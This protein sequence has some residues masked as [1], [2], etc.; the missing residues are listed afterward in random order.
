MDTEKILKSFGFD[1]PC[2][3]CTPL[4][5][6][7]LHATYRVETADGCF[8]LQKLRHEDPAALMENIALVTAH[9]REHPG[10][11][12]PQYFRTAEGWLHDGCY[13]LMDCLPGNPLTADS[14][15][16]QTEAASFAVG[17][18]DAALHGLK[19]LREVWPAFHDTRAYLETLRHLR[20]PEG[21]TALQ[22]KAV[23]IGEA[24]CGL[25]DRM[26]DGLLPV[27]I[28][29][30]DTRAANILVSGK[31]AAVIDLDTVGSGLAAYDY[32]DGIR[33]AAQH[34][35]RLDRE[36]FRAFTRGFLRGMTL[37]T[38]DE[39]RSLVPGIYSV[40][41]EL[42]MR[43]LNDLAGGCTYFRRTPEQTAARAEELLAFAFEVL[44]QESMLQGEVQALRH[45]PVPF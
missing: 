14:P 41:A 7:H 1:A 4:T 23:T 8:I 2:T 25:Y 43:Y 40:T 18:F 10:V 39:I 12:I 38:E 22:R 5:E 34:D 45:A 28:V 20:L 30:G 32:G 21:H 17:R 16:A 3:A 26:Q 37:L 19:G 13:R 6:G 29:H 36:R 11:N 44:E 15:P 42:A 9:V 27:R 33:S 24:A 31:K 35:G